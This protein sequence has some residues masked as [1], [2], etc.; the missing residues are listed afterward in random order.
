MEII[1]S[2]TSVISLMKA[3]EDI[4]EIDYDDRKSGV[5]IKV[6]RKIKEVDKKCS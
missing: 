3:A 1:S 4:E 6:K 2:I 5:H